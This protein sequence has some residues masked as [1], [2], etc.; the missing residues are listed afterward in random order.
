MESNRKFSKIFFFFLMKL[1]LPGINIPRFLCIIRIIISNIHKHVSLWILKTLCPSCKV[2]YG[3]VRSKSMKTCLCYD[4]NVIRIYF[5]IKH[6]NTR[7]QI[8]TL[9]LCFS[10]EDKKIINEVIITK[11]K[12]LDRKISFF[13]NSRLVSKIQLSGSKLCYRWLLEMIHIQNYWDLSFLCVSIIKIIADEMSCIPELLSILFSSTK[14]AKALF[15]LWHRQ[16]M[17]ICQYIDPQ[18]I[19]TIIR[20]RAYSRVHLFAVSSVCLR[21]TSKTA[22]LVFYALA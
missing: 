17:R 21:A 8:I 2:N 15:L 14:Y 10:L 22:E 5:N 3:Y 11:N 6:T 1:N 20:Q 13:Q 18:L 19:L 4:W 16:C 7:I 12:T 9:L